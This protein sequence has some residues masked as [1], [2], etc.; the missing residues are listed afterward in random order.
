MASGDVLQPSATSSERANLGPSSLEPQGRCGKKYYN[1]RVRRTDARA[2]KKDPLD[3]LDSRHRRRHT[4][5]VPCRGNQ[6]P[7][8]ATFPKE[9]RNNQSPRACRGNRYLPK[10]LPGKSKNKKVPCRGNHY[11]QSS[12]CAIATL[13]SLARDAHRKRKKLHFSKASFRYLLMQFPCYY[14]LLLLCHNTKKLHRLTQHSSKYI[15]LQ[16][17]GLHGSP[18]VEMV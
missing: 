10:S 12:C 16:E 1:L 14:C 18:G 17:N 15:S 5:Q 3:P 6:S 9:R 13:L 2:R 8:R 4:K 7:C 11:Y